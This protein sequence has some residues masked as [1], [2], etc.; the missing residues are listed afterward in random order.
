MNLD[1][2]VAQMERL[3]PYAHLATV[4]PD[5][6]PH[7]VPIHADWHEGGI[8]AMVGLRSAKTRNLLAN[9]AVCLHYQVSQETGWDSL[10]VWGTGSILSRDEDKRRLWTG[11]LS[12]DLNTFAGGTGPDDAPDAAFL[13]IDIERALL[14]QNFGTSGRDE[15]RA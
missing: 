4:T 12:Y 11:V 14:L 10:I 3:G 6:K 5:G 2:L 1:Q 15:Y 9:P 13:K 7:A 8:Y